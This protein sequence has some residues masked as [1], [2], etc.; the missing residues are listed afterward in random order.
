MHRLSLVLH[1]TG[2]DLKIAMLGSI[3]FRANRPPLTTVVFDVL[4]Y[5]KLSDGWILAVAAKLKMSKSL[6][7]VAYLDL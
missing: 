2:S 4:G 3:Q 6:L 7:R 1:E 5:E